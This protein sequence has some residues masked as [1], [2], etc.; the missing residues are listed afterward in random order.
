VHITTGPDAIPEPFASK[1][2]H[3]YLQPCMGFPI[4]PG[5]PENRVFFPEKWYIVHVVISDGT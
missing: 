1:G 4:M 2:K 5:V 3:V